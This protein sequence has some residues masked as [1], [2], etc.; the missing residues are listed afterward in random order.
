MQQHLFSLD[1][2][3]HEGL[4]SAMALGK[5]EEGPSARLYA[6]DA[7]AG[8]GHDTLFL[9]QQAGQNGEV[10]AFDT[11][12]AAISATAK[13]LRDAGL[14]QRLR[15]VLSGHEQ[16]ENFLPAQ[17]HGH[18]WGA[19][20]NLGFLPGSDRKI[21][22][23]KMSTLAAMDAVSKLLAQGGLLSVHCYTGHAGGMEE[24]QAVAEW[25]EA[26]PWEEWRV[27]CYVTY[28]KKRNKEQLFL[29]EKLARASEALQA[30]PPA[31]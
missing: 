14:E 19:S 30:Q 18:V 7:T 2:L 8:N 3:A 11:Q 13:R 22:T 4:Q 6:V 29:A 24:T 21:R 28:N 20:F 5:K 17:A 16:M 26:L 1:A 31:K 27:F 25:M 12:E 23:R 9:A 10:W 15:L